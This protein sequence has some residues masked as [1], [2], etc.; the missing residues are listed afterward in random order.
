MSW[1]EIVLKVLSV[2]S[3]RMESRTKHP[4]LYLLIVNHDARFRKKCHKAVFNP[5]F[6]GCGAAVVPTSCA[7]QIERGTVSLELP[8]VFNDARHRNPLCASG[9]HQRV[10]DINVN[11][12]GFEVASG[13][14]EQM[15]ARFL[16][17]A[18]IF[19]LR[20][21]FTPPLVSTKAAF[22]FPKAASLFISR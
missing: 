19:I 12:H 8:N 16:S 18:K 6:D 7:P 9:S 20:L 4:I 3:R 11:N 10:I 5:E 2:T 17:P 21:Y 22:S 14:G 1:A 13:V 15:F